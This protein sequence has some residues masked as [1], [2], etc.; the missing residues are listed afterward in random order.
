M[1]FAVAADGYDRYIG[2][3]SRALAP[4]FLDFA[5]VDAGPVIDVGCGPGGLTAV[6]AAR[7]GA[8]AVAAVDL[9]EPFVA[10]CRA[11][12]P[13]ADVRLA[14]AEALPFPDGAF[15]GALS[16]LVLAFV[17][18]ADR[19]AAEMRRVLRRGGVAAACMFE[20]EGF[21]L[22]RTFWD[23]AHRLDP[24]APDDARLP[25]RTIPALV[26]LWERAGLREVATDAIGVEARY[27]DFDDFWTPFAYGIGPAG[28]YLV[29]QTE[30]R[31]AAIREACFERLGR[32]AG[33]FTLPAGVVAV[34]GKA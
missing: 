29:R 10:A 8:Q 27:G 33:A 22:A 13:G 23:A 16:Q 18:D 25:F 5:G 9:S 20:A 34:R 3:Y 11:R 31:R 21:A 32:P 15:Q 30:E 28:E 7:F 4:R 2:R 12:V 1:G 6:L 14:P 17:R 19:T 24:S 26:A